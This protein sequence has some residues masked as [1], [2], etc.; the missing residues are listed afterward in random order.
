MKTEKKK[1]I[2]KMLSVF[3]VCGYAF[4]GQT[5][6]AEAANGPYATNPDPPDE[7]INID[8]NVLLSWQ[9][10]DHVDAHD[11]YIG[12]SWNDVFNA[13]EFDMT[14]IYKGWTIEPSYQCSNLSFN[15]KYYWRVDEVEGRFFPGSGTIYK[16][17]AYDSAGNNHGSIFGAN[18]TT[19]QINGALTFD[20]VGDYVDCAHD[21]S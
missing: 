3:L 19:G 6:C 1:I 12:T 9:A 14:D 17:V 4:V 13:D 2:L 11:V 8:P 10:G 15:T 16:G 18:W 20:G 21:I 7:A 5:I